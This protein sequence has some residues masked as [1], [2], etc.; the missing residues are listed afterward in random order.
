MTMDEIDGK[1]IFIR[2]AEMRVVRSDGRTRV[3]L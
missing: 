1:T 3:R 2:I